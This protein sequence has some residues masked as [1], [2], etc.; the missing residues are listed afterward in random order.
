MVRYG[1]VIDLKK[2]IG[3][4]TCTIACKAENGTRPGIFWNLVLDQEAGHY[5][6]VKR[7]FIP[8]L[9]MHCDNAPCVQACPTGAS[10]TR[11]DGLVLIDQ[12]KCVGCRYCMLACPY[13]ARYFN[14]DHVGYF[15]QGYTPYE[16][17]LYKEHN[18]GVVEKCTFCAHRIDK[19]EEPACV[20]DCP[21]KARTFG[22]LSDPCSEVSQLIRSRYGSRFLQEL[23]TEPSVYYLLP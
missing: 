3:C 4:H 19:D 21:M 20:K 15:S 18:T 6:A 16:E 13:K 5:P 10:Y 1:M 11:E 14:K 23:G 2:C 9:C 7:T 12:K 17:L 8:T 22:D